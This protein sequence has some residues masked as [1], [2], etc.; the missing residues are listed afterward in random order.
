MFHDQPTS[1]LPALP[2]EIIEQIVNHHGEPEDE[3]WR[4]DFSAPLAGRNHSK[5]LLACHMVSKQFRACALRLICRKIFFS[6]HDDPE[7]LRRLQNLLLWEAH[8]LSQLCSPVSFIKEF[9]I[10][11]TYHDSERRYSAPAGFVS[12]VMKTIVDKVSME[13]VSVL[14]STPRKKVNWFHFE[15]EITQALAE[16]IRLPSVVSLYITNIVQLPYELAVINTHLHT[17]HISQSD[18][19]DGITPPFVAATFPTLENLTIHCTRFS[20]GVRFPSVRTIDAKYGEDRVESET[21]WAVIQRSSQSLTSIAI[22]DSRG[23]LFFPDCFCRN[24]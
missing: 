10:F 7:R 13:T 9:A 6:L 17:L 15:P 21:V 18:L 3:S 12:M 8:P 20:E 22:Y 5:A 16:I 4:E 24:D 1:D 2:L 14:G 19:E 23:K 11:L